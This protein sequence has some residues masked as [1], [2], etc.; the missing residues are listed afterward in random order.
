MPF[1]LYNTA[2]SDACI[3]CGYPSF[4]S[5]TD[6]VWCTI[7]RSCYIW[8]KTDTTL[9]RG[10]S[11]TAELLVKLIRMWFCISVANFI[12]IWHPCGVTTSYRFFTMAA[13]ASEI[14]FRFLV[15]YIIAHFRM[16]KSTRRP[17][18]KGISPPMADILLLPV[19]KTITSATFYAV[20]KVHPFW[21]C[22]NFS[23][24]KPIQIIFR[25]NI[26][27]KIWNKLTH[28]N[29]DIYSLC[30]ASLRRKSTSVFLSIP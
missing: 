18:F 11:A 30:V 2:M 6:N 25:R 8:A 16:S 27:D 3:L 22:D 24:C 29:F 19:L 20:S 10:F 28:G 23:N 4:L 26:T 13:T 14:Y 7:S 21:F 5:E 15:W 1:A 9:Q 17:N 12:Q